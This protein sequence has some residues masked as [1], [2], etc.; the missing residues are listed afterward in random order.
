MM[1][2]NLKTHFSCQESPKNLSPNFSKFTNI[3]ASIICIIYLIFG[4]VFNLWHPGW[5]IFFLIPITSTFNKSSIKDGLIASVIF[6]YLTL[7]FVFGLWHPY[8]TLLL[9]II[10]INLLV[11]K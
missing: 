1:A 6:L 10:P 2:D 8:W 3:L 7:G 9:L 5:V 4:L 11:K